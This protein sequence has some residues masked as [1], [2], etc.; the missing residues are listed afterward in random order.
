MS[1]NKKNAPGQGIRKNDGFQFSKT[2]HYNTTSSVGL[3][4]LHYPQISPNSVIHYFWAEFGSNDFAM[5]IKDV[6]LFE[7]L[8]G[9]VPTWPIILSLSVKLIVHRDYHKWRVQP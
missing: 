4:T 7:F 1:E 6:N 3:Q 2:Q 5:T 8:Y 9:G